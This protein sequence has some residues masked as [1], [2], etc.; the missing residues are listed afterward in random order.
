MQDNQGSIFPKF[1]Q[2]SRWVYSKTNGAKKKGINGPKS[3]FYHVVAAGCYIFLLH[4]ILGHSLENVREE[5]LTV[6]LKFHG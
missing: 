6:N 1:I 3:L 4:D 2:T 5:L